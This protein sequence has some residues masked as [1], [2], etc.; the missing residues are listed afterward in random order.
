MGILRS[1][2][3]AEMNK[4]EGILSAGVLLSSQVPSFL[5]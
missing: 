1:P 3:N 4:T 2:A 5:V